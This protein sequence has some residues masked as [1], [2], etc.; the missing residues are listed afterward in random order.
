ME[1]LKQY[2]SINKRLSSLDD[3]INEEK[4]PKYV[5]SYYEKDS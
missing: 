2:I 5:I 3:Y 1:S 4:K